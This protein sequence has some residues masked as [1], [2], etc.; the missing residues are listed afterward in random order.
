MQP[1]PMSPQVGFREVVERGDAARLLR[2]AVPA[3]AVSRSLLW[4]STCSG[5]A[6]D[7]RWFDVSSAG[8]ET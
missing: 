3:A 6:S 7:C 4:G 2:F 5:G 8:F 1:L